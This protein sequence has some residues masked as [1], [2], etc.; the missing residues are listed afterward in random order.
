ME[1]LAI[2]T[3]ESQ[4]L[5]RKIRQRNN[6]G[7]VGYFSIGIIGIICLYTFYHW[8]RYFYWRFAPMNKIAFQKSTK[9]IRKIRRLLIVRFPGFISAGHF[10]IFT[11]Y[12]MVSLFVLFSNNSLGN[13]VD[14]AKRLGWLTVLNINLAVFLA[15]KNTPLLLISNLSHEKLN[16]LHQ[17]VGYSCV[18][19]FFL[20]AIIYTISLSQMGKV[21]ILG[22]KV[23]ILGITSGLSLLVI[24]FTAVS[25]RKHHYEAFY[26]LH[27]LMAAS[28]LILAILHRPRL[29]RTKSSFILIFT[30]IVWALDRILRF[31]KYFIYGLK[32]TAIITPLPH[33]GTRVVFSKF[34]KSAVPGQHF[35]IW[36][37]GIRAFETHPFTCLSTNPGEFI[38]SA[39]NGFT[40]SLYE[41]ALKEPGAILR[42]SLDGPYGTVPDLKV[43]SKVLFI[44]GGS[45]ASFTCS[46]ATHLVRKLEYS[47]KTSIDFTLKMIGW[48]YS[49]IDIL[50]SSPNVTLQIHVTQKECESSLTS[51]SS[52]F[53]DPEKN[54]QALNSLDG[55]CNANV[56]IKNELISSTSRFYDKISP[57]IIS[58]R[59]N[60]NSIISQA[61]NT[62]STAERIAIVACGPSDMISNVRE[63]TARNIHPK[64]P[65]LQLF[66]EQFGW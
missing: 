4:V 34:P 35:F 13:L 66:S 21:S 7:S 42:A 44:A 53:S 10:F 23:Q 3:A 36:L 6:E 18:T 39:Q 57:K 30:G 19:F 45:G 64:G 50:A 60:L 20:H 40:R 11:L 9:I 49:Y 54:L 27:I 59:P 38:I 51:S 62:A 14:F 47:T 65:S 55:F 28:V 46:L 48:T 41:H 8:I 17:I 31:T 22:E 5:L 29:L 1:K 63:I 43:F 56:E 61:V 32:N 16:F 52:N 37:P 12:L 15:L 24:L 33:R 2:S 58:G 25:L 26:L